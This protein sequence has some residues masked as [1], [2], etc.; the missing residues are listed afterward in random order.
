LRE[1]TWWFEWEKTWIRSVE[2]YLVGRAGNAGVTRSYQTELEMQFLA[3]H[4][5][6]TVEEM[7]VA[8]EQLVPRRFAELAMPLVVGDWPRE[9]IPVGE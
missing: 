4:R 8:T 6:W 1:H 3:G 2:R 9:P 7:R 5:W